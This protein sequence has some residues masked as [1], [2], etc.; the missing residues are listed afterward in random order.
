MKTTPV[1]EM[2]SQTKKLKWYSWMIILLTPFILGII[3]GSAGDTKIITT[4]PTTKEIVKEVPGPTIT[5]EIP[6]DLTNWKAL[7]SKDDEIIQT[8]GQGFI[9]MSEAITAISNFDLAAVDRKTTEMDNLSNTITRL[10]N[11]RKDILNKLGY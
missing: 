2:K 3:F 5:K 7:K 4:P 8:T 1:V 10:G 6:A 11:E 9:V